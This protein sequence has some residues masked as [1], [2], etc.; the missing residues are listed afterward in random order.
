[1][2]AATPHR[3]LPLN[4]ETALLW[5]EHQMAGKHVPVSQLLRRDPGLIWQLFCSYPNWHLG[6]LPPWKGKHSLSYE[7]LQNHFFHWANWVATPALSIYQ[8]SYHHA[9]VAEEHAPSFGID[10]ETAYCVGFLSHLGELI[11]SQ[12]VA[13][14]PNPRGNNST[15]S[16][17]YARRCPGPVWFKNALLHLDLPQEKPAGPS[18]FQEKLIHLLQYT[19]QT[20]RGIRGRQLNA[21]STPHP[22]AIN[23][24]AGE[25]LQRALTA[26][27]PRSLPEGIVDTQQLEAE[28]EELR[29][30]LTTMQ[31]Q[32]HTH[33]R[34]Q[35]LTAMAEL[36]AGAG[37]EIN[38]P[39]AVISAQAQFLLKH[40]Q[41]LEQGQAL[42]RI[43]K[44]TGRIHLILRDLML[45][46]RP[47]Q[48]KFQKTNMQKMLS[49]LAKEFEEQTLA[50]EVKLEVA[51]VP[52]TLHLQAD[53]TLLETAIR[54][55]IQNSLDVL[56]RHGWVRVSVQNKGQALEI[57]IEDNG[58]GIN[59]AIAES[60][61]DPFFSG[62]SAG[63]GF[64]LGLSKVWR[65]AELH[66][67]QVHVVQSSQPTKI[68]LTIPVKQPRLPKA[69]KQPGKVAL[70]TVARSGA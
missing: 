32:E 48:P 31:Q 42:Q 23:K 3:W 43:H 17:Y 29:T 20:V 59:P 62:R 26:N 55:I 27:R 41:E 44:Q 35:K 14:L 69:D 58:P 11:S 63:R 50:R 36:A 64:G 56:P 6:D 68:V 34:D 45:F 10:P 51:K 9:L 66:R 47:P 57:A 22:I 8:K 13:P 5:C 28:I 30:R 25:L 33:L 4:A 49:H 54:C 52:H 1:M 38:N 15:L 2:E 60:I 7:N 53:G 39:L 70:K 18:S 40:T 16:R 37:H 46:A 67:G 12:G 21:E 19:Q 61:F 65:I 24:E